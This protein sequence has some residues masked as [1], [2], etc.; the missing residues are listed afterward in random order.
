MKI[1]KG[2]IALQPGIIS[3]DNQ[4]L[5]GQAVIKNMSKEV[6]SVYAGLV[7]YVL[8]P[9]EIRQPFTE[10]DGSIKIEVM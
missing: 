8:H 6:I 9:G 3:V 1:E 10:N 7:H 5:E 4:N 2:K